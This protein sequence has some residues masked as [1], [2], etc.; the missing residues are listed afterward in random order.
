MNLVGLLLGITLTL[1]ALSLLGLVA[2][3]NTVLGIFALVTGIAYVLV[4]FG[5]HSGTLRRS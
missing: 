5:V 4:S 1:W 3:S 2:V